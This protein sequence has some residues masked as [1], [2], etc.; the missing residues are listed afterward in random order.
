MLYGED[1]PQ[2]VF[3]AK[4]DSGWNPLYVARA[5]MTDGIIMLS[6]ECRYVNIWT[7]QMLLMS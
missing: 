7:I 3:Q 2:N 5:K 1:I 4:Y 6:F